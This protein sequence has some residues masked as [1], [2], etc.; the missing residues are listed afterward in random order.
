MVPRA[1]RRKSRTTMN[2]HSKPSRR[3]FLWLAVKRRD[4]KSPPTGSGGARVRHAR[5]AGTDRRLVDPPK[6]LA[7][8]VAFPRRALLACG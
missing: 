7:R 4:Q 8:M 2:G 5:V 6:N 1:R 3:D